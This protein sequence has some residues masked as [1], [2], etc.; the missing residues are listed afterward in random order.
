[1]RQCAPIGAV[2]PSRVSLCYK[3]SS[4]LHPKKQ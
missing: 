4:E 1:L 3:G 2:Y